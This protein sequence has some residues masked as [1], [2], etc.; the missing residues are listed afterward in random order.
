MTQ[1]DILAEYN[2]RK[3]IRET[4]RALGIS[5]GVVRKAL[6]G[7][8]IIDTPLTRRIDELRAA[9]MPQKDIAALLG[10]SDSCI[11]ANAP[12][13]R[14]MMIEPSQTVNAQRIRASR[15]RKHQSEEDY[16]Q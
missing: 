9:G 1:K 12:Y 3:S 7:Y 16:Q 13:E 2:R 6:I 15:A 4:A 8:R 5:Q 10:K 14:G 11:N